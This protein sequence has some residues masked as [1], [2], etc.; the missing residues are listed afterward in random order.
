MLMDTGL[1]DYVHEFWMW[2]PNKLDV[3]LFGLLALSLLAAAYA[4]LRLAFPKVASIALTTAKWAWFQP[5]FWVILV[6]GSL[7]LWLLVWFPYSTFG[8]DLKMFKETCLTLVMLASIFLAVWTASVSIAEE[9]EGKTALT[10]LSKPIGRRQFVFGKF[11]GVLAPAYTLFV[12]LGIMFLAAISYKVP[13]DARETSNPAP[14]NAEIKAQVESAV[15]PL[16]LAFFE[17]IVLTSITIAISTRLPMLPN[18][19]ICFSVYVLG[20][21]TPLLVQ[22]SIGE[23]RLVQFMG[24]FIATVLPVLDYFKCDAA[25]A[26]GQL[27][28]GPGGFATVIPWEYIS[29]ALVYTLLYSTIAMLVSLLLFEDRD[30]A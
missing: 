5:L 3:A 13:Y 6:M 16:V 30:L 26:R 14:Q 12:L 9:L 8:E 10:V 23:F 28:R 19:V 27:M 25:I 20:H 22:S 18:L 11:L 7:F 15:V 17:T 29:H 24:K 1:M 2:L 4:I 21:L